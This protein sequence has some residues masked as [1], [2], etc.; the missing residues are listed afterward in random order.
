MIDATPLAN[1][2]QMAD[3]ALR[4]SMITTIESV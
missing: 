1:A 3:D 4:I 2:E